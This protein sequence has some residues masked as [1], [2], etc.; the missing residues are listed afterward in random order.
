MH[1]NVKFILKYNRSVTN[2]S[3]FILFWIIFYSTY[4]HS[5][6][7]TIERQHFHSNPIQSKLNLIVFFCAIG[8]LLHISC[9]PIYT[10]LKTCLFSVV[11]VV[12]F[13]DSMTRFSL[14]FLLILYG[15]MAEALNPLTHNKCYK[16]KCKT[17]C[18]A[19]MCRL[20]KT[21]TAN[22]HHRIIYQCTQ[23]TRILCV[24][25]SKILTFYNELTA[26][27]F[28]NP[29]IVVLRAHCKYRHFFKKR[30]NK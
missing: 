28:I 23:I 30:R 7:S 26:H 14:Y 24:F 21:T 20:N 5:S 19:Q 13:D 11:V 22:K 12:F 8:Q 16:R 10:K 17:F 25:V 2:K 1:K 3:A 18:F 9:S 6:V 27:I 4:Q 15:V 29:N